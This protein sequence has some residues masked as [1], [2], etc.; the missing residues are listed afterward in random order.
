MKITSAKLYALEI[1]FKN[2]FSHNLSKRKSSDSIVIKLTTESGVAG[3]GEGVPRSYVTGETS[4]TCFEY[5]Q[6]KLLPRIIGVDLDAI[7]LNTMLSSIND[8]LGEQCHDSGIVWNAS[9]AAVEMAIVDLTLRV[10]NISANKVFPPIK[11]GLTYSGVITSG[12]QD[13]VMKAAWR[14]KNTGI[15][16]VK[17]KVCSI[18]DVANIATVRRLLGGKVSI[19]LDANAAFDINTAAKFAEAIEPFNIDCIEQPIPRSN[20][21][22]FVELKSRISIPIM[23]DESL[24]TIA[25]ARHLVDSKAVDYFNL[26][27]S[28]CGGI[29]NALAIADI[30]K[31]AG[32]GIQL[33][34]QV[35]ETAILSSVGRLLAAY[36]PNLKWIEGSYGTHLL[37]E[38]ISETK[39]DIGFS[40]EA[41]LLTKNGF[42]IVVNE[43]VLDK[44]THHFV[45]DKCSAGSGRQ[46]KEMPASW[47]SMP[48]SKNSALLEQLAL[49]HNIMNKN[50]HSCY[51]EEHRFSQITTY[52]EFI[53]NIPINCFSD[54][55]PYVEQIK[56]GEPQILTSEQ[57][58]RFNLT[59]GTT[60]KP[61]YIP[62]TQSGLSQTT[63]AL[64]QWISSA[65]RT[66]PLLLD[67]AFVCISGS[68]QEGATESGTPYGCASGLMYESLPQ[69]IQQSFVLPFDLSK[70][71]D[72]DLRYY[73]MARLALESKVS[74]L[75]TPNPATL[76]RFAETAITHQQEIINSIRNGSLCSS[77]PAN[78]C[79]NDRHIINAIIPNLQSNVSRANFLESQLK[80]HG[81]LLPKNYWKELKLIGCWLGGSSHFQADKLANYFGNNIP[82][83]D[84]GYLASEGTMTIPE[85]DNTAT[86]ALALQNNFYEFIHINETE[87]VSERTLLFHQLELGKQYRVIITNHNGLYRYDIN[88]IIEVC[89]Y[90]NQK[91]LIAF[92]RKGDDMLN[93]TGE[94]LHGNHLALA[95]RRVDKE[96]GVSIEQ[97]KAVPNY[98][99]MCYEI[100]IQFTE[101]TAPNVSQ[102][103]LL[104]SIDNYLSEVN[105]EYASKRKSNRL[106]LPRL[107]LMDASWALDTRKQFASE[108]GNDV[109]YK[110]QTTVTKMSELD[111]KHMQ[112]KQ[113]KYSVVRPRPKQ[114]M[115]SQNTSDYGAQMMDGCIPPSHLR[116]L[117]EDGQHYK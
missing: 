21:S 1:P 11:N 39:I 83:R 35:G 9:R 4:E 43:T 89:G 113:V 63:I 61:K 25:D 34:C 64:Q 60:D 15:K 76:I 29:F 24:V 81:K 32:I 82:F 46:K 42:G 5:I 94:K 33:G 2:S 6:N 54:L 72:Y 97:F 28:K 10:R 102:N 51:G 57:V 114:S 74:F 107:H 84:I 100:L 95:M 23:A 26:R 115:R 3:Y 93:I 14:C 117:A 13:E 75:V 22:D 70:I 44:Y 19:R 111:K 116:L 105:L 55:A 98:T 68:S 85:R 91:P 50:R 79:K 49:L 27:I 99:K 38:D 59:S 30:A 88:D 71:E 77:L 110:W 37:K 47:V 103:K 58:I 73:V 92:V 96:Y 62:V 8:L 66:H 36:I 17:M 52:E 65:L 45:S 86:G 67:H 109:Q 18:K 41:P 48:S 16:F 90:D 12:T 108:M 87:P 69:K 112:I 53:K 20:S 104:V 80:Q 101:K 40:G 106:N 31:S 78:I 7:D 56:N